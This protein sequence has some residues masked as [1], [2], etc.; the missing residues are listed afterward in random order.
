MEA[1]RATAGEALAATRETETLD[2]FDEAVA[3]LTG[4]TG[5]QIAIFDASNVTNQLR[6]KLQEK[7]P[8]L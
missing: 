2:A 6:A 7:E 5:A 8:V 3:W 4:T 1:E